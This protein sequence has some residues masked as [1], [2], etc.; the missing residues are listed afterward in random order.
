MS[1]YNYTDPDLLAI[2]LVGGETIVLD[3]PVEPLIEAAVEG[4]IVC[5]TN[6]QL[7]N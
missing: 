1:A 5:T 2:S 3:M 7:V 6:L 4:S